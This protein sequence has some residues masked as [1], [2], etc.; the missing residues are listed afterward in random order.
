MLTQE[1]LAYLA[2]ERQAE[3]LT[4]ARQERQYRLLRPFPVC[5]WWKIA[6]PSR[7]PVWVRRALLKDA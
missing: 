7:W 2:R 4:E 3:L 5:R 1:N 6:L